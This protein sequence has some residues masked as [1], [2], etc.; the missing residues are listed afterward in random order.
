MNIEAILQ[1]S[2]IYRRRERLNKMIDGLGL[3]DVYGATIERIKA[4]GGDKSRL[5]MGDLMWICHTER[6]LSP[7]ELC[8]ALAIELGSTDF[9]ASNMPSI[10]TLVSCCQGLITTDKGAA[11][12]RLFRFTLPFQPIPARSRPLQPISGSLSLPSSMTTP[13]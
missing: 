10:M 8:H 7:D 3:E 12:V 1:E 9:N 6:P 11:T 13:C 4:Q 5:G 2:T